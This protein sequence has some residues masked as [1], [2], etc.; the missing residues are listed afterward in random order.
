MFVYNGD[1]LCYHVWL[2]I[3][4]TISPSRIWMELVSVNS[5]YKSMK[6]S[7]STNYLIH[8]KLSHSNSY[9]TGYSALEKNMHAFQ[10]FHVS[11]TIMIHSLCIPQLQHFTCNNHLRNVTADRKVTTILNTKQECQKNY[12]KH[13]VVVVMTSPSDTAY[14]GDKE[15]PKRWGIPPDSES[16][17]IRLFLVVVDSQLL[18]GAPLKGGCRCPQLTT[19][20][21]QSMLTMSTNC[22][23][24][25]GSPTL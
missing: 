7:D 9:H 18:T 3:K 2:G 19:I 6:F 14:M 8:L 12:K 11:N 20:V 22:Q 5:K 24:A 23:A 21:K 4:H 13:L 16:G 25:V 15:V 17:G 1:I 10:Q